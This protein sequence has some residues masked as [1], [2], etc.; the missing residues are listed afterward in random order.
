MTIEIDFLQKKS[1]DSSPYDSDKMAAEFIQQFN[2]QGFSV[3]QQV[4]KERE[5]KP[6]GS[7]PDSEENIPS[8]QT[9]LLQLPYQSVTTPGLERLSPI[10]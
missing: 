4:R 3:T 2:N 1:T 9:A 6:P 8:V 7:A 5:R 10:D